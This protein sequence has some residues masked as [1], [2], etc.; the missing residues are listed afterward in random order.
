MTIMNSIGRFFAA[1]LCIFYSGSEFMAVS[2]TRIKS[3]SQEPIK[4]HQ[5]SLGR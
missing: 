4:A 3:V 2:H 5:I 1:R